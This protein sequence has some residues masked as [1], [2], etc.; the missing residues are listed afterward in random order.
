METKVI[1]EAEQRY[2]IQGAEYNIRNDGRKVDEYR[3][4]EVQLGPI[5]Q[6]TGSA[7]VRLGGT[8]VIVAVKAEIGSPHADRPDMGAIQFS[9]ECSPLASPAFH[10]RRGEQLGSEISRAL[11]RAYYVPKHANSVASGFDLGLLKIVSGK[12]CWIL[13]VDGLILDLDGAALDAV[14]I[15]VKCALY[16]ARIPSVELVQGE[17]DQGE[18]ELEVNDD[19]EACMRLD[20]SRVP[21]FVTVCKLGKAACIDPTTMEEESASAALQI[22]VDS[23]GKVYGITKRWETVLEPSNLLV[24]LLVEV[25]VQIIALKSEGIVY[26][27]VYRR[28]SKK[29]TIF[30]MSRI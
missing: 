19:P 13:Y 7:R 26:H 30:F 25:V 18:P 4:V 6:A 11:E 27:G 21:L 5:A 23:S 16:D 2:I 12:T 20:T 1:G 24:R 29:L 14:S 9:V 15:A 22:A 3:D 8:D 10:G 17:G 28:N